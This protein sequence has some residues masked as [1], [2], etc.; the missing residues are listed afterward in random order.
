MTSNFI[1]GEFV[2]LIGCGIN[3]ANCEPTKCINQAIRKLQAEGR[4][5]KELQKDECLALIMNSF[6]KLFKTFCMGGFEPLV[7]TYFKRWLHR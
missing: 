6:D 1:D 2:L 5:I 3:L 4:P 7:S